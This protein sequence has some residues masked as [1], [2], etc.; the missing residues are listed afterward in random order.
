MYFYRNNR[1]SYSISTEWPPFPNDV[2]EE[3]LLPPDRGFGRSLLRITNRTTAIVT[4]VL[5]EKN[6]H[7]ER[8]PLFLNSESGGANTNNPFAP[9]APIQYNETGYVDVIGTSGFPIV[10]ESDYRVIVLM[11]R[12]GGEATYT[13]YP[14]YLRDRVVEIVIDKYDFWDDSGCG[15]PPPPYV[16]NCGPPPPPP[17][18]IC[19]CENVNCLCGDDCKCPSEGCTC[20]PICPPGECTCDPCICTPGNCTC[21]EINLPPPQTPSTSFSI[22]S[23][24]NT[25][26]DTGLALRG[27]RVLVWG[28]RGSGQQ[29][30]GTTSVAASTLPTIVNSLSNIVQVTGSAYT[31]VAIDRDGNAWG[32]GQNLYG[33]AG[34]GQATGVVNRPR[35]INFPGNAKVDYVAAGEYFFIARG[36]DGSVY[37]WG[38]NLYGQLGTGGRGNHPQP[39][40]VAVG[41][42]RARVVGAAYE[43]AFVVTICNEVFAWGDNEAS[44]LGFPGPNYG[45]QSIERSPTR[46]PNLSSYASR[47]QYIAGGNGWGQALLN[48]GDVIG[49]GLRAALGEGTTSVTGSS[50]HTNGQVVQV[51]QGI[52]QMHSRY[53]G[54]IALTTTGEVRTWGQTG[55]SAFPTIYGARVTTRQ[56]PLSGTTIVQVGGGKEHVYYL[57][58]DGRVWGAGYGALR[59]LSLTT[60]TNRSW[61]GIIVNL[62]P[63]PN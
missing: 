2:H 34:V 17:T 52:K 32:W 45:V 60:V 56:P 7:P 50:G 5:I 42:R 11:A 37:T 59:K 28:F 9:S 18:N 1:G 31:L 19:T 22:E 51:T 57:D 58:Q 12:E 63:N 46:V 61:P 36:T 4:S 39:V 54:T 15:C 44:G 13:R 47:I 38:H 35:Q 55:G 62:P 14:V 53:V 41:G 6:S 24:R 40:R 43:G 49:W 26:I 33:A 20:A 21:P 29:G 23:S 8:V 10:A 25:L 3:D 27:D 30:N 48:N 16:C